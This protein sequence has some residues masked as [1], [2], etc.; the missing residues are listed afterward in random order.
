MP[1]V[2]GL[3]YAQEKSSQLKLWSNKYW[4]K[5]CTGNASYIKTEKIGLQD[6]SIYVNP[7]D[8]GLSNQLLKYG[9]REPI[10]C[11]FLV[12][13]IKSQKPSILDVGGNIG[14][15]P[16]IETLSKAKV[17]TVYEPVTENFKFLT[18]NMGP[19]KR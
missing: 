16:I 14:Y 6:G 15:F 4:K 11:Y 12:K 19:N 18:K 9:I 8:Q 13:T 3:R 5:M 1:Q 7:K 2:I 10:N 17:V